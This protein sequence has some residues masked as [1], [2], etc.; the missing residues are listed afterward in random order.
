MGVRLD[1]AVREKH[2]ATQQKAFDKMGKGFGEA[3]MSH[4]EVVYLMFL[5]TIVQERAY[6]ISPLKIDIDDL[7]WA[8]DDDA[9]KIREFAVLSFGSVFRKMAVRGRTRS[10]FN[11]ILAEKK[12]KGLHSAQDIEGQHFAWVQLQEDKKK[13][14]FRATLKSVPVEPRKANYHKA[15]VENTLGGMLKGA[16]D[17]RFL[18]WLQQQTPDY[19]HVAAELGWNAEADDYQWLVDHPECD[20]ATALTL[21]LQFLGVGENISW[22]ARWAAKPQADLHPVLQSI[23]TRFAQ[24][25]FA[26]GRFAYDF[27]LRQYFYRLGV[28]AMEA[29]PTWLIDPKELEPQ[30]GATPDCPFYFG[31]LHAVFRSKAEELAFPLDRLPANA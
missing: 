10:F 5:N 24:G 12:K 27:D 22:Q 16:T 8:N 15:L 31:D 2:R 23:T 26:T 30:D 9:E 21:Y 29:T 20:R 3:R 7:S 1:D 11:A 4:V 19:W 25:D 6:D 17:A 28:D 18:P 14:V 13:D